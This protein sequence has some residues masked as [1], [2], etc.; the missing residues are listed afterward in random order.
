MDEFDQKKDPNIGPSKIELKASTESAIPNKR[1][2]EPPEKVMWESALDAAVA[3]AKLGIEVFPSDPDKKKSYKSLEFSDAKWGKTKSLE[4]VRKDFKKWPN[5]QVG[6]A[7]GEGS[8][9]WIVDIDVDEEKNLDGEK[10]FEAL[11]LN[12][13]PL[14]KTVVVQTPRGGRHFW[15]SFPEGGEIYN[16]VSKIAPGIDIRGE[17]GI[18]IAPPSKRRDGRAYSYLEGCSPTDVRIADAPFWLVELARSAS[19]RKL[20]KENPSTREYSGSGPLVQRSIERRVEMQIAD[21][22]QRIECAPDGAR[23]DILNREGYRLGRMSNN[24]DPIALLTRLQKAVKEWDNQT[25]TQETA[26]RAFRDG[27]KEPI[28]LDLSLDDLLISDEDLAQYAVVGPLGQGIKHVFEWGWYEWAGHTWKSIQVE[29]IET[30]VATHLT[31]TTVDIDLVAEQEA[32]RVQVNAQSGSNTGARSVPKVYAKATAIRDK[33]GSAQRDKAV[34][35]K[36]EGK[37]GVKAEWFNADPTLLGTPIGVVD[38]NSG[39]VR[40]GKPE[41]LIS[42]STAVGPALE[43]QRS[44]VWETFLA[45]TFPDAS[46]M[47]EF[48]QRLAGYALTGLTRDEKFFFFYGTGR[49]GKGVFLE[50]LLFVLGDYVSKASADVFLSHGREASTQ[51]DI[52]M[53]DGK[54]LVWGDEVQVGYRWD[55]A[56]IKNLTGG[57]TITAKKLYKDKYTF[58]PQCTVIIAGNTKPGVLGVDVAIRERMVLV[59]FERTFSKGE[60]DAKLKEVLREREGE[61][62]LRWAI[63]GARKYLVDGLKIPA[64]VQLLS[65][66]YLDDVDLFLRFVENCCVREEKVFT[67]SK[68]LY[69]VYKLWAEDQ[70]LKLIGQRTLTSSLEERGFKKS[71]R[72]PTRGILGLRPMSGEELEI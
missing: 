43:G 62:V 56:T 26:T 67:P 39:E 69:N 5:A 6:L 59:P 64:R 23:S 22:F 41:D 65:E 18:V 46:E 40:P 24:V 8:G 37:L 63:E 45:S 50:T 10:A 53:I 33:L 16:S 31:Q 58:K 72:G 20:P 70:G 36:L 30:K 17:G 7:T 49:N 3:Y 19:K 38:L 32:Q 35:R 55:V 47:I 48:L 13:P 27:K 42:H 54:R 15:F 71:K 57:D 51:N 4:Q 9:I 52:A 34:T 14:P 61:K 21:I 1:T 25:K 60:A 2:A 28:Q 44:G 66:E 11:C 68:V 29:V 12:H